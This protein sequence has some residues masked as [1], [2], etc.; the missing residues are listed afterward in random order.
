[1]TRSKRYLICQM[2]IFVQMRS[3]QL[4]YSNWPYIMATSWQ[5]IITLG[6]WNWDAWLVPTFS[7]LI[8]TKFEQKWELQDFFYAPK[9]Q[10]IL[11]MRFTTRL[12]RP[13]PGC[14]STYVCT[15][16]ESLFLSSANR[17]HFPA[18]TR[19][20]KNLVIIGQQIK[21]ILSIQDWFEKIGSFILFAPKQFP[22]CFLVTSFAPLQFYKFSVCSL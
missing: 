16:S 11:S 15:L 12:D 22:I 2:R 3:R 17:Y 19:R 21:R 10:Y 4:E 13:E 6:W 7:S 5:N 20:V 14:I 18:C 9:T 8:Y 1:M